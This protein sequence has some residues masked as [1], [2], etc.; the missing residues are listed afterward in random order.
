MAIF[1]FTKFTRFI[2]SI[3]ILLVIFNTK[4]VIAEQEI[5]S[6]KQII[7][8]E[9]FNHTFFEH[10]VTYENYDSSSY[11]FKKF[12]GTKSLNQNGRRHYDDLSITFDSKEIRDLYI[13]MLNQMTKKNRIN[14]KQIEPFFNKSI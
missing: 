14:K 6:N 11:Q 7:N 8:E 9:S 2:K 4:S 3:F 13:Q 1:G 10:G 5:K 12:F